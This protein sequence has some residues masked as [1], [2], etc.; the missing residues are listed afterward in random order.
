MSIRVLT[1]GE[2]H[3][4]AVVAVIDGLPFGLAVSGHDIDVEL[5]RR[6]A[7][8][9]RGGRMAIEADRVS[10]L[11]GVRDGYTLGS[12]V[13]L[14]VE[15]RDHR[16]WKE[17]MSAGPCKGAGSARVTAPRPG[18]GDLSGMLKYGTGDARDVLERASARETA[19]RSAAGAVAKRLLAEV[20]V[21]VL[22]RVVAIG[23]VRIPV[24]T[25]STPDDFKGADDDPVRCTD[26]EASRLMVK[27][28]DDAGL[29]GETLGGWFEVAAFGVVP[30]LGS[31]AQFDRRLDY[32][33][34]GAMA[35]VPGVK[36]VEAGIGF[37][38]GTVIGSEAHDEII[39]REGE[40]LE[41]KTNRAGGL[42][43]G[44]TNGEPLLLRA[45]MKPIPTL[46]RPLATVDTETLE[47]AR[48][49]SERAD[50]CAVPA[51]SVVAEGV[52]ALVLAGAYLEKFGSDSIAELRRNLEGYLAGIRRLWSGG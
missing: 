52:V 11:S 23:P 36:G 14:L 1:S 32:R 42:E 21:V 30:G 18:H 34:F 49:A 38:V 46:G 43:A 7:G 3:G 12:P 22:S 51:A 31:P 47:E 10:I 25:K 28:I 20:G 29:D 24:A 6:Q 48:A 44:M 4:P 9:G 41:R 45:V 13:T 19:A 33:L 16:N 50:V 2:S 5:E 35:S 27:A 15:N 40:G 37:P 26:K 8:H 17:V 39:H